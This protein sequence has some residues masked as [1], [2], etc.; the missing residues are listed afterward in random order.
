MQ[1]DES[2][3]SRASANPGVIAWRVRSFVRSFVGRGPILS[4]PDPRLFF[5][6]TALTCK[7]GGK[8]GVDM[9]RGILLPRLV[10]GTLEPLM[11][12]NS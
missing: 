6:V 7:A 12:C 5:F 9:S 10:Q 3:L 2:S 8:T 4:V 11:N 1:P